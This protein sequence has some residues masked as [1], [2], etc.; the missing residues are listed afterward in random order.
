M[1][2]IPDNVDG[3]ENRLLG[4]DW[5]PDGQQLLRTSDRREVTLWETS[6]GVSTNLL[7]PPKSDVTAAV[8]GPDA[9]SLLIASGDG[10]IRLWDLA[11]RSESFPL[12]ARK[13]FIS[14]CLQTFTVFDN[15]AFTSYV[16]ERALEPIKQRLPPETRFKQA[17]LSPD[18]SRILTSHVDPKRQS[19]LDTTGLQLWDVRSGQR[20]GS[21]LQTEAC[22]SYA[23][24]SLDSRLAV[25]QVRME[26][27][28]S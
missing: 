13:D 16:D 15:G 5:R 23:C 20:L 6:P 10:E 27:H 25:G 28:I 8:Y 11:K 7:L 18:E 4:F 26:R 24:F 14:T 19:A 12:K 3:V 1:R 21:A 2:E 22:F 17:A 9:R